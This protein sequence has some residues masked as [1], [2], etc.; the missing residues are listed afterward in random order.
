MALKRYKT[1]QVRRRGGRRS[2]AARCGGQSIDNPTT[3]WYNIDWPGSAGPSVLKASCLPLRP[4]SR[5][6]GLL[7]GPHAQRSAKSLDLI[8][9]F[10]LSET[11]RTLLWTNT[12][13]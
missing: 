7:S 9:P 3:S 4:F 8:L 13:H 1:V 12:L 10:M 5:P 2:D 6:D 11:A